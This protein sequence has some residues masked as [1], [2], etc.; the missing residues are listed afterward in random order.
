MLIL[1]EQLNAAAFTSHPY[2][3][4]VIGWMVDIEHWTMEDLQRH[5]QV[6]YSPANATMIVAGDVTFDQIVK[7]AQK[8]IEPIPSRG[9]PPKVTTGEP[10]QFRIR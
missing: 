6:G 1:E 3:W 7:L 9:L 4:P 2:Q 8:Y 10:E 5:F